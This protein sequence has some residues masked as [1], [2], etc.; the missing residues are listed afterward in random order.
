MGCGVG[1]SFWFMILMVGWVVGGVHWNLMG[2]GVGVSFWFMIFMVGWV[3]GGVRVPFV[4]NSW[5]LF[6]CT[7]FFCFFLVILDG[8]E[9]LWSG[10][11]LRDVSITNE[12]AQI[13]IPRQRFS[14]LKANVSRHCVFCSH[15]IQP[16]FLF[17]V[18]CFYETQYLVLK[19]NFK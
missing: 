13:L 16:I 3:V 11:P 17:F 4:M 6:C 5:I 15:S 7:G 19:W 12:D 8:L 2:C 9:P 1:V 14:R 10:S 18:F